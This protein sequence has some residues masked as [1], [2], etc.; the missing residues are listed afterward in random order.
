MNPMTTLNE[1]ARKQQ[2]PPAIQR[3]LDRMQRRERYLERKIKKHEVAVS[4]EVLDY[5]VPY[6]FTKFYI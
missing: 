3:E 1:K 6:D 4:P 5:L 2:I